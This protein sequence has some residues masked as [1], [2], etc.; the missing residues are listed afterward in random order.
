MN[1]RINDNWLI[2]IIDQ[3]LN[4]KQNITFQFVPIILMNVLTLTLIE[5]AGAAE[6][7]FD[8]HLCNFPCHHHYHHHHQLSRVFAIK[9]IVR[10]IIIMPFIEVIIITIRKLPG[11]DQ[12]QQM[13]AKI[14]QRSNLIIMPNV[15][16]R[17]SLFRFS[18]L[19]SDQ[20][21]DDMSCDE[22][23]YKVVRIN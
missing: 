12:R 13:S 10:V 8:C 1:D 19:F 6:Y 18:C 20:F 5:A 3:I 2:A 11:I 4:F 7:R 15:S 17:L 23:L 21:S 16:I 9:T 22:I 14:M